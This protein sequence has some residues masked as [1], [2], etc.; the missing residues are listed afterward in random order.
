LVKIFLCIK[1]NADTGYIK[2]MNKDTIN[3]QQTIP[4]AD[5]DKTLAHGGRVMGIDVG[6]K[7]L[8]IAFTILGFQTVTPFTVIRRSKYKL[9]LPQLKK[10]I[11]EWDIKGLIFGLPLNMDGT[12][13]ERVYATKVIA[14]NIARDTC[15]PY[16]FIDERLS[17]SAATDRLVALGVRP[18]DRKKTIDAH[19]AT[20]IL[21]NYHLF[22]HNRDNKP[23][24]SES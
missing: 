9:D 19:A 4:D 23:P 10:I 13:G 14:Q 22:L 24:I 15:L 1:E 8:G 16:C 6:T 17:T 11:A 18:S 5:F 7:T 3:T 2:R 21:E 12:S 20:I